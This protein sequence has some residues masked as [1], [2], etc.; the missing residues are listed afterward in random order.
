MLIRMWSNRNS[1]LLL[2]GMQMQ[3]F[4][5]MVWQFPTKPKLN[6]YHVIQE[7]YSLVLPK[8]VENLCPHKTLH[9]DSSFIHN[10]QNVDTTK[11]SFR[12]EWINELYSHTMEYYAAI[13]MNERSS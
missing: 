9:I 13:K 2:V 4:W 8:E 3:P 12:C 7:Q 5:K 1:H 11:M 6:S 10:Y